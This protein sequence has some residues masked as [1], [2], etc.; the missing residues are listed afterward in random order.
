MRTEIRRIQQQ[1][2]ITSIYVTHDQAE[3]MTVSD[4]IMVMD[5]GRIQQLGTPFEI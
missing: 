3:A 2:G 1:F 4:R 5:K